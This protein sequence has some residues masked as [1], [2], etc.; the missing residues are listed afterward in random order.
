M[1]KVQALIPC[2]LLAACATQPIHGVAPGFFMGFLHGLLA[3]F[4]LLG[5]LFWNVR[6]YAFPN[7]GFG[8]DL[9]FVLGLGTLMVVVMLLSI[10]RIGGFLTREGGG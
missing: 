5:S 8:Y 7:S 10:A 2:L 1:A 3:P 4:A 9:G 6:I